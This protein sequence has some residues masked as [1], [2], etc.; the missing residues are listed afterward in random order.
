MFVCPV[1][2]RILAINA[3]VERV[4]TSLL[5]VLRLQLIPYSIRAH[6]NK[7]V[8]LSVYYYVGITPAHAGI[9]P[10]DGVKVMLAS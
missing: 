4:N 3:V 10:A 5:H 7:L 1:G 8:K 6:L 9:T 2:S